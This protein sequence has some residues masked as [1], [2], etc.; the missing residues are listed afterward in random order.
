VRHCIHPDRRAGRLWLGG[1]HPIAA[2]RARVESLHTAALADAQPEPVLHE[3]DGLRGRLLR[4]LD[5]GVVRRLPL[6]LQH[7]RQVLVGDHHEHRLRAAAR[8]AADEARA[9]HRACEP[10]DD[11]PQAGR[12]RQR[13]HGPRRLLVADGRKRRRAVVVHREAGGRIAPGDPSRTGVRQQVGLRPRRGRPQGWNG[14]GGQQG[15]VAKRH[16]SFENDV[17]GR[18]GERSLDEPD[19]AAGQG[20]QSVGI[21]QFERVNTAGSRA[22]AAAVVEGDRHEARGERSGA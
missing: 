11:F 13:Q 3:R 17:G 14:Q 10:H 7:T 6:E 18:A 1:A 20:H 8:V 4:R 2:V 22:D 16:G 15:D 12:L 21:P 19:V 5:R 9:G